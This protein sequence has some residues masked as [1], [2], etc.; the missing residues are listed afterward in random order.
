MAHIELSETLKFFNPFQYKKLIRHQTKTLFNTYLIFLLF[1]LILFAILLF[2]KLLISGH[3][4]DNAISSFDELKLSF[5]S[6]L[7]EKLEINKLPLIVADFDKED[8]SK[9]HGIWISENS[10][11]VNL[12][13]FK[14]QISIGDYENL[15]DRSVQLSNFIGLTLLVMFPGILIVY[16]IFNLLESLIL[17]L[18]SASLAFIIIRVLKKDMNFL[19]LCKIA[20]I[21]TPIL[22]IFNSVFII[23]LVN[24]WFPILIYFLFFISAAI[25]ASHKIGEA[26]DEKPVKKKKEKQASTKERNKQIFGNKDVTSLIRKKK[27]KDSDFILMD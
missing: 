17:A 26:S 19:K 3:N 13:P 10:I 7:N 4:I 22:F 14:K 18:I 15:K 2:P 8:I 24:F 21:S 6:K 23:Y 20:L 12:W 25:I 16:G 11:S 27:S 1:S 5:D 9:E